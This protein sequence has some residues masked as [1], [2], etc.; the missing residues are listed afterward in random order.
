MQLAAIRDEISHS[1]DVQFRHEVSRAHKAGALDDPSSSVKIND[2]DMVNMRSMLRLSWKMTRKLK[3]W[4]KEHNIASDCEKKVRAQEAKLIGD[5]LEGEWVPL[6][7]HNEERKETE[8]IK[9]PLVKVTSLERKVMSLLDEYE[10]LNLLSFD[11]TGGEVWLKVGGDKGGSSFKMMM[12]I[13]NVSKPNSVQNTTIVLMFDAVDNIFNLQLA[14]QGFSAEIEHLTTT[15]WRGRPLRAFHFGDYEYLSKIYGLTGPNGRHCCL[16]CLVSK[17]DMMKPATERGE[18]QSRTLATLEEHLHQFQHSGSKS[19][20][21]HFNVVRQPLV[22][23]PIDQVCPPGLHISLGL[24]LKHFNSMEKACHQLDIQTVAYLAPQDAPSN[25]SKNMINM[26][27][28]HRL[29][30]M[31]A[32]KEEERKDLMEQLSCFILLYPEE[33]ASQPVQLLQESVKEKDSEIN[34][35]KVD[36]NKSSKVS[37]A[38]GMIAASLDQALQDMHVQR[39]AY[40]GKSFIGNHVHKCLKPDN[41]IRLTT[42]VADTMKQ[43]C[44]DSEPLIREAERVA[45]TYRNLFTLFGRC[46]VAINTC[47]FLKDDKINELE[48]NIKDYLHFFRTNFPTESVPPKMH[49]LEEHIVPW[50][51][52]WRATMGTMGEQGGE[53]VHAQINNI[54]RDLRGYNNDLDLLLRSVRGQWLASNP[55]TY[56][57]YM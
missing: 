50:L 29:E 32:E 1:P 5:N 30:A 15:T 13:A 19:A 22:T 18:R 45:A 4:L 9:T 14:L 44:P 11:D 10:K 16:Y 25:L 35:V 43:L 20:K 31:L 51:R 57:L 33:A 6:Q 39:Q 23:I 52:R 21:D 41:I 47:G 40:H 55:Q 24:F 7:F 46:H 26:V 48:S 3:S 34:D 56:K 2:I 17:Q 37:V 36:L 8:I 12:Q 49:L 28:R 54:K 27:E 38:S 53:S 42:R